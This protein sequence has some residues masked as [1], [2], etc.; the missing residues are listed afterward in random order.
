METKTWIIETATE[1]IRVRGTYAEVRE[2]ARREYVG[3]SITE[4]ERV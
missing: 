2:L 1:D 3:S 4:A